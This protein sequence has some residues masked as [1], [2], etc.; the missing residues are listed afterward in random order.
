MTKEQNK[1]LKDY[2]FAQAQEDRYLGSVFVNPLGVKG[3]ED[4]VK[5]AYDLCKKLG[6]L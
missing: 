5:R 2:K 6:A 3:Y 1:A 4:R